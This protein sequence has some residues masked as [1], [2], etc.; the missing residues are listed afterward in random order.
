[1]LI[2]RSALEQVGAFDEGYWMY[3][4]DLDLC[5][6]FDAEGWV[7]WYEPSAVVVHVKAGTSGPIRNPKLNR[8]FHYGM[9]RFYR[10]FYAPHRA[11][12]VNGVVYAGIGLK[13]VRLARARGL[14]AGRRVRGV[15][16][17]ETRGP[18]LPREEIEWIRRTRRH[19]RPTQ[20]DYLVL[21]RLVEH[22]ARRAARLGR[23]RLARGPRRLLRDAALRGP[24]AGGLEG[25]RATTSTTATAPPTSPARVPAL[26]RRRVRPRLLRRGLLLLP[27][28]RSRRRLRCCGSRG[29]AESTVVTLPLVWEYRADRLEHRFTAPELARVFERAGLER[30]RG[31]R[32]R[33]LRGLLVPAHRPDHARRRGERARRAAGSPGAC[34]RCSPPPTRR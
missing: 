16:E 2:R 29:P 22:V 5:Y 34:G 15:N 27:R 12:I 17:P 10:K 8:A 14:R 11:P 23:R 31:A 1:M 6:R 19:P 21:R 24:D 26:R 7:T 30:G 32:G 28:P 13:L 20:P 33:R 25:D 4:E 18:T 3:M 9:Y